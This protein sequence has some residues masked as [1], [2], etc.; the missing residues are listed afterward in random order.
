MLKRSI[1]ESTTFPFG[2]MNKK[3]VLFFC[4]EKVYNFK[5]M[6]KNNDEIKE[7]IGFTLSDPPVKNFCKFMFEKIKHNPYIKKPIDYI[8][9]APLENIIYNFRE[10]EDII[11][12]L[13]DNLGRTYDR[14]NNSGD[15]QGILIPFN[16]PLYREYDLDNFE[17]LDEIFIT[18]FHEVG[19]YQS[20]IGNNEKK[21]EQ[22][23]KS[24]YRHL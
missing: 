13:K 5:D 11:D 24:Q 14:M 15:P 1:V 4:E 19:H 2:A 21:A 16:H 9:V 3:N 6:K 17:R 23:G 10:S 8:Y 22:F 7:E 20:S 12:F 18:L